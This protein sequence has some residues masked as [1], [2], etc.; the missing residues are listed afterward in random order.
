MWHP[1]T[2][3][4]FADKMSSSNVF[5]CRACSAPV[6][7]SNNRRNLASAPSEPVASELNQLVE[8][9]F[10]GTTF[11]YN[12]SYVYQPKFTNKAWNC[13]QK[14]FPLSGDAK[15]GFVSGIHSTSK[16]SLTTTVLHSDWPAEVTETCRVWPDPILRDSAICVAMVKVG[17]GMQDWDN[18]HCPVCKLCRGDDALPFQYIVPTQF[19]HSVTDL[20]IRIHTVQCPVHTIT[21][22]WFYKLRRL[23][24][25]LAYNFSHLALPNEYGVTTFSETTHITTNC[26]KDLCL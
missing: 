5:V 11:S 26:A 18:R 25:I 6:H 10:L 9:F 1:V 13:Q 17:A 7:K 20:C 12:N 2:L 19:L 22:T 14:L 8:Q 23:A 15:M 16:G 21:D 24:H 3:R 4:K